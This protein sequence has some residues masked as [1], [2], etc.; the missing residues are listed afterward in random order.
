MIVVP[1]GNLHA[2]PW[3]LLP[4]LNDRVVS[5]AP[6][7]RAWMRAPRP[8]PPAHRRVTLARGP[9]LASDGAE[10]PLVAPSCTTT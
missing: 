3:T 2:I 1:P 6:S 9:G 4:A 8:R 5:V 7:A 10:V